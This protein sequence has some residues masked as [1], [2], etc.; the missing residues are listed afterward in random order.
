MRDAKVRKTGEFCGV[1]LSKDA[2]SQLN[3]RGEPPL[4]T[5]TTDGGDRSGSHY[6]TFE[7]KMAKAEDLISRYRRALNILAK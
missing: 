6:P 4:P 5:E 2:I 1:V 3:L 7:T